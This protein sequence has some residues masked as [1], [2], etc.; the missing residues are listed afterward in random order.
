MKKLTALI[1][2]IGL[3]ALIHA[4]FAQGDLMS[5]HEAPAKGVWEAVKTFLAYSGFLNA[6]AGNL[7]MMAAGLFFI[8]LAIKYEYE[9]L[10][11]IPIGMGIIIGNIPFKA[12]AGLMIGI[13]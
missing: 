12:G 8:F 3:L 1:A 9:P 6:H 10:L 7:I 2:V 11:L 4:G 5:G 13:P